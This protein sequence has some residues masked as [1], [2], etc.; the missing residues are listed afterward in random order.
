[1][2][3]L[4]VFLFVGVLA[5]QTFADEP[6]AIVGGTPAAPGEFPWQVSLNYHGGHICGGS[7]IAPTKIL[8]AAHCLRNVTPSNLRILTGTIDSTRGQFHAV[9][10]IR[11]HP[12]YMHGAS[13]AW[14]NDVAVITLQSPIQYNQYQSPIALADSQT[15]ANTLCILSGWGKTSANGPLAPRLLK[16]YQ[17][18]ILLSQC[19]QKHYSMPLTN[20][21]VCA[22]NQRGI[23]ACQGDSG[24]PLI[25]N[26]KQIGI[27]S[28][29]VPCAA[30][31]PDAYTNVFYHLNFIRSS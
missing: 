12:N 27:T 26:G 6:E 2:L 19:Q 25:A 24:G 17:Y 29:V 8:T 23:G 5:Q 30:G 28:W 10:S 9:Q 13:Y 7:I 21:H 22:L 18:V 15:A 4:A 14:Q 16:M 3:P 20:S 11:V 1:M 31:E